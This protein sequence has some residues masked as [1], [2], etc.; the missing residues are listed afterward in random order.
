MG[1]PCKILEG[2]ENAGR[3]EWHATT[4]NNLLSSSRSDCHT[5]LSSF[6]FLS[7]TSYRT[8]RCRSLQCL[9]RSIF[10]HSITSSLRCALFRT[11]WSFASEIVISE[12]WPGLVLQYICLS[13]SSGLSVVVNRYRQL[14]M[15]LLKSTLR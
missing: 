13:G 4:Q 3:H 14:N 5:F 8:R 7:T 6:C 11:L 1:K 9:P 2:V 10:R 15:V 12:H